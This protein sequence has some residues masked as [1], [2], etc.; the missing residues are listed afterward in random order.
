M[1]LMGPTGTGKT[2]LAATA[3]RILFGPGRF[4]KLDMA[5][6]YTDSLVADAFSP[7]G[8]LWRHRKL[9]KM[10][11][12]LLL[13]EIDKVK[14]SGALRLWMDAPD[15]GCLQL[16][17]GSELDFSNVFLFCTSNLACNT[18]LDESANSYANLAQRVVREHQQWMGP[19]VYARF[20]AGIVYRPLTY[21]ARE[22]I[23]KR[24]LEEEWKNQTRLNNVL[25]IPDEESLLRFFAVK[26]YLPKLGAR[27]MRN[28]VRHYIRQAT[29]D[30]R[31][32]FNIPQPEPLSGRL[33]VT[34]GDD[35][36]QGIEKE[37]C[38]EVVS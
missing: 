16:T 28:A 9:L 5:R 2:F 26:G 34:D 25:E 37:R 19:E 13:D 7:K 33:V 38:L 30:F 23:A 27:P 12:G 21:E 14:D 32:R 36:E 24:E 11:C 18:L 4:V 20:R 3:S 8:E 1:L 31:K 29:H 15:N 22:L 35:K 10:G 17:D 6:Y